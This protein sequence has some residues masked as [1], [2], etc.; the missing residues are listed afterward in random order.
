MTKTVEKVFGEDLVEG[1]FIVYWDRLLQYPL[2]GVLCLALN[3]DETVLA[4]G[5]KKHGVSFFDLNQ[6]SKLFVFHT[7]QLIP[8]I[9]FHKDLLI[10]AS[11]DHSIRVYDFKKQEEHYVFDAA[12]TGNSFR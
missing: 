12:H 8:S 5:I 6:M 4:A 3:A 7:K 2:G 1:E 9:K 10:C 11:Y